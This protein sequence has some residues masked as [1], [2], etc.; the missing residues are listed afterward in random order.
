MSKKEIPL[1]Q[2][3]L[4]QLSAVGKQVDQD[5][6]SLSSSYTSL[7]VVM[8]KFKDNKGF[9]KD[10]Q[11]S[12]EKEMLIPMTQA[13]FIPG[14]CSDISR[15]MVEL[16]ANYMI[17]T[18]VSKAEAFCDR[19]IELLNSHMDK[20]DKMIL[21]KNN[22]LNEINHQIIEKNKEILEQQSK[23]KNK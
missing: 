22:I 21:E 19:K 14:K 8:H 5:I 7:K 17:E 3:N 16:G 18:D 12:K 4:E 20:I 10:L 23:L 1:N 6:Q 13:V 11:N 2:L 15:L 9:I